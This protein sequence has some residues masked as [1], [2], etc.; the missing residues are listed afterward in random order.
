VFLEEG[1]YRVVLD[2]LLEEQGQ[3]EKQEAAA[4]DKATPENDM[5]VS[6]AVHSE[7][8]TES[9]S[10]LE[11]QASPNSLPPQKLVLPVPPATR[12]ACARPPCYGW[13]SEE[14]DTERIRG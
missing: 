13:I 3:L 10:T 9:Q 12:A 11:Q 6:Q 1:S 4:E 5:E 2:K 7:V 14:S 8:P